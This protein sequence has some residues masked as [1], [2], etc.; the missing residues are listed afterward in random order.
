ML[1]PYV[2]S[3]HFRAAVH[4][5]FDQVFNLAGKDGQLVSVIVEELG[6]F[7]HGILVTNPHI[8]FGSLGLKEG[9]LALGTGNSTLRLPQARVVLNLHN[10]RVW[11]A[12]IP[13]GPI[14]R[15]DEIKA[16]LSVLECVAQA[17]TER[18]GLSMLIRHWQPLLCAEMPQDGELTALGRAARGPVLNLLRGIR[19]KNRRTSL[20]AARRLIGLGV[21]STPSGDDLLIGFLLSLLS[22]GDRLDRGQDIASLAQDIAVLSKGRTTWISQAFLQHA[23]NNEA[24]ETLRDLICSVLTASDVQVAA[25]ARKVLQMGSTSGAELVLGV[26]LGMGLGLELA[27]LHTAGAP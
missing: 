5:V 15:P 14:L 27:N 17:Y 1:V 11:P 3:A 9:M 7:P 23:A 16:N 24:S 10:A 4:S 13:M 20:E 19:R 6:N 8:P 26:L 22:L 12:S 21:G 25:A 18:A 2:C